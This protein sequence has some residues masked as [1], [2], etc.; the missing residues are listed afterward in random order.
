MPLKLNTTWSRGAAFLRCASRAILEVATM[1]ALR[2]PGKE[3]GSLNILQK[4]P[5][6]T[7][8]KPYISA[9]RQLGGKKVFHIRSLVAPN[10]PNNLMIH[11]VSSKWN[12]L[13]NTIPFCPNPP[14][15]LKWE[16][17]SIYFQRFFGK[18]HCDMWCDVYWYIG[19][20]LCLS[21]KKTS[22]NV[23]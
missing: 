10:E 5:K 20:Q 22:S 21:Q 12:D 17:D 6:R 19:S 7:E 23:K 15:M 1:W 11:F 9:L 16:Q 3:S 13:T 2:W 4:H 18:R 8:K 14:H